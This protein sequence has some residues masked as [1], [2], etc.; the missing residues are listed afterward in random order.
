MNKKQPE[1]AATGG[2]RVRTTRKTVGAAAGGKP[3]KQGAAR[4][5]KPA[6]A[7][8]GEFVPS[9]EPPTGAKPGK[10]KKIR[11]VRD[12]F[13]MP[14]AEHAQIAALKKRCLALGV[15]A[16][17]SEL[18]RAAVAHLATLDDQ[19]VVVALERLEAVKTGRPPKA[20][21]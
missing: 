19:A 3:A 12:S 1:A 8:A 17:K 21:K 7:A 18:L 13:T 11:L 14:E 15:A 10:A 6:T 20:K 9:A 2:Q 5:R 16:R 4:T